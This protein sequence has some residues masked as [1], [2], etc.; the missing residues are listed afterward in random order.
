[1]TRGGQRNSDCSARA[2]ALAA[3][4]AGALGGELL[5]NGHCERGMAEVANGGNVRRNIKGHR[6][7]FRNRFSRN[8][9][10]CRPSASGEGWAFFA[11]RST[12]KV[13]DK[14]WN[15]R[16]KHT[17]AGR[18]SPGLS[19]NRKTREKR[20]GQGERRAQGRRLRRRQLVGTARPPRETAAAVCVLGPAYSPGSGSGFCGAGSWGISTPP[21]RRRATASRS[22]A[23]D[24]DE[25]AVHMF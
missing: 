20:P 10:I 11:T 18:A 14:P 8:P 6:L 23:R 12:T 7:R 5:E 13:P 3:T 4:A 24:S 9:L 16:G 19:C 2:P 22:G 21:A 15:P 17:E 1:M 25:T